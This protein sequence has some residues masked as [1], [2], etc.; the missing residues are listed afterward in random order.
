M[1]FKEMIAFYSTNHMK[2][3]SKQTAEFF[4]DEFCDTCK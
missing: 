1:N 2:P 3:L 4:D